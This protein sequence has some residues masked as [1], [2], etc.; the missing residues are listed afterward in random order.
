MT[1]RTSTLT[2]TIGIIILFAAAFGRIIAMNA[3][4]P[5]LQHDEIFKA[6]EGIALITQGDFRL[7]YP[8][9]Q[10]HE[11]AFV[12]L[13][14]LS[15]LLVGDNLLMIKLPSIFCGVLTVAL[16]YRVTGQTFG[17]RVAF[18]AAGLTAV[19]FWTLYVNR[20]GLRATMLPMVT[21]LVLWGLGS[22]L[23]GRHPYRTAILTGIALGFAIYTYTSSFVVFIAFGVFCGALLVFDRRT[24]RRLWRPLVLTAVIAAALAAPMLIIRI[25]DPQGTNRAST[26]TRPLTDALAGQ[27]QEL[28]DN[29][30]K[31]IGMPAFTGDPEWRY[32]IADRPLFPL[33]VGVLVYVGAALMLWRV[34]RQPLMAAY[35]ALMLFGLIPSLLTVSAPSFLRSIIT[36]PPVMLAIALAINALPRRAAWLVGVVVVGGVGV[37]DWNT[38]FNEW[39]RNDE[40]QAIYRDDLEQLAAYLRDNEVTQAFIT[41]TDTGLDPTIFGYYRPPTDTGITFL[42][43]RTN[44]ALGAQAGTYLF[45]SPDSPISPP[46]ADWLAPESGAQQL[47]P[48]QRQDGEI[49]YDVYKLDGIAAALSQRLERVGARPVY[50]YSEAAFPSPA[51]DEW[52]QR[53]DTPLNFGGLVELVGVDLPRERIASQRDGVNID[54]YLRPL[55]DDTDLPL[56]LFVHMSR[57]NGE[58]HAQRDFLGVPTVEWQ[59]DM[60]F[61]QDNFVIAGDTPPGQYIISM[62]IYNFM[63]QQRIPIVNEN[64]QPIADRVI[65]GVIQVTE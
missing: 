1:T 2:L 44:I 11:G 5:G 7:F 33:P 24:L 57:L 4:P 34:R 28:I 37:V 62:G 32:N 58:V 12:W 51:L 18:I 53:I 55:R 29:G 61:I 59:R 60:I 54:L 36:V 56:N 35:L 38:Y 50:I 20:V 8:T 22:L 47:A 16:M 9:N 39:P 63:T 15:Y 3:A 13:L 49:A 46:H 14:G 26:I 17:R 41:T 10:G 64:G 48:I 30:L 65:V 25:T 40:V 6:Q 43:G 19:S 45:V 42:D 52:G 31:L 27:P 23:R 21:L